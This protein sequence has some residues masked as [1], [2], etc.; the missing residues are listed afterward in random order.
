MSGH[1]YPCGRDVIETVLPHRPPFLWLSRVVSC[2]PGASIKAEFDLAV[3]EPV[4][5]GH[6]PTYP[7]FPGVLVMEALA[8]AAC[9]CILTARAK[10]GSVGFLTGIDKA[11]FRRQVLPGETLCLEAHIVRDSSR[12]CVAEVRATVE[13]AVC[14]T[15]TQTY[16]LGKH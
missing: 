16:V 13:G 8:Q 3:E 10:E 5:N 12:L 9:F 2:E 11:R 14:A 4:F 6:F 7:V 15:A 1:V